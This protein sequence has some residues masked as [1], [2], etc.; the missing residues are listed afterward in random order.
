MK[1]GTGPGAKAGSRIQACDLGPKNGR[2]AVLDGEA[3][4]GPAGGLSRARRG[5]RA[6]EVFSVENGPDRSAWA[7][8][9]RRET[10]C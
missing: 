1:E 9:D 3:D 2:R 10:P 8:S 4:R 7:G 6:A 5:C